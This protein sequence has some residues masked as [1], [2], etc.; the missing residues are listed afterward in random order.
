[1]SSDKNSKPHILVRFIS[2][3]S[4]AIW[5]VYYLMSDTEFVYHFLFLF[6]S[7]LGFPYP[8]FFAFHMLDLSLRNPT[9]ESVLKAVT[10]NGK[11]I[12]LTGFLVLVIIYIYSMVAFFSFSDDYLHTGD[13]GVVGVECETLFKCWLSTILWGVRSGGGIGD[14]LEKLDIEA[15]GVYAGRFFFDLTFFIIVIILSL[16]MV[17]GIILDTFGEL[18]EKKSDIEED[19]RSRCFIC[20]LE[21]DLF[22]RQALGFE[23]HIK[24]EHNMWHY[25]YYFTYLDHKNPDDY[26]SAE[27]HVDSRRKK[28]GIDFFPIKRAISLPGVSPD[29]NDDDD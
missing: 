29:S 18:R 23:H 24:H 16:N 5:N 25:L 7:C 27:I 15:S 6:F 2:W 8:P 14:V 1:L 9:V 19:I 28:S 10:L 17:F 22:Q 13:N 26:T 12:L 4:T 21:S 20:S 3:W 11:A